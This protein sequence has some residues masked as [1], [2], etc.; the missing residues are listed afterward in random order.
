MESLEVTASTV[1]PILSLVAP[2]QVPIDH[3]PAQGPRASSPR[4][5]ASPP[6]NLMSAP[7]SRVP[8]VGTSFPAPTLGTV[9]PTNVTSQVTPNA[10][11]AATLVITGDW[12]RRVCCGRLH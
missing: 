8:T 1:A 5:P 9:A 10:D 12:K 3:R 6:G 7:M 4:A 11:T 2:I